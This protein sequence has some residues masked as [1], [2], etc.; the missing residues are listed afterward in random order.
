MP[1]AWV[2]RRGEISELIPSHIAYV[3]KSEI[4]GVLTAAISRLCDLAEV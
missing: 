1:N 3:S 2:E 4:F